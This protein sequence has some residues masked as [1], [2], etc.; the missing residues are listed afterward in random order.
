M[1]SNELRTRIRSKID[2]FSA[3]QSSSFIPLLGE[4]CVAIIPTSSDPDPLNSVN[5]DRTVG[6]P[7][8][9]A[10]QPG[11]SPYAIGLKVGDGRNTFA[12]LPWIQAIA[13]DVFAWAKAATPP[14]AGNISATYGTNAEINNVQAA[15]DEIRDSFGKIVA[16]NVDPDSLSSAL[17][18]LQEQLSGGGA[19]TIFESNPLNNE[20]PPTPTYPAKILRTIVKDGLSITTTSSQITPQD[21]PDIPLSKITGVA[22]SS[23]HNYNESTNPIV[24][25]SYVNSEIS[26]LRNQITGAMSFI[27]IVNE[28]DLSQ[29]GSI[30]ITDGSTVAPVIN[31]QTIAVTNL[32]AG[33]VILYNNGATIRKEFVWTGTAW[34]E[35]GDEGSFAV[36]GSIEKTDLSSTLQAEI[37][38]KLTA[39]QADLDAKLDSTTAASTYVEKHNDDRLMTVA[40]GTK[41]AGIAAGAQVNVIEEVQVNGTALTVT[42]K[43]VNVEVPILKIKQKST[44]GTDTDVTPDANDKSITLAAIAFDGEVRNLKQTDSTYLVFNCGNA[45][46]ELFDVT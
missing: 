26:G 27:G 6:E 41:L 23:G 24:T 19:Q 8:V 20:D 13:G 2:Y 38:D 30:K 3:W 15:L 43:S 22:F 14:G 32:K 12:N 10:N 42:N 5:P 17:E 31:N 34:E 16:G 4:I 44:T 29:D 45:T 28:S 46:T 33:D 9:G 21:L 37:D 35:L 39:T 11:L 25:Q 36:K 1:A 18:A 40:E 7:Q